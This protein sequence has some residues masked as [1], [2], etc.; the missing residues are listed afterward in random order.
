MEELPDE[1][2]QTIPFHIQLAQIDGQLVNG[3]RLVVAL[4][5][6]VIR[7]LVEEYETDNTQYEPLLASINKL[8]DT[9]LLVWQEVRPL[10]KGD[11]LLHEGES[12]VV[13]NCEFKVD[14]ESK[15]VVLTVGYA[16][17]DPAF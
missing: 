9:I 5:E 14:D 6:E 1:I 8:R 7:S 3:W 13:K 4:S 2:P 12:M 16:D 17:F 11:T 10:I 15:E